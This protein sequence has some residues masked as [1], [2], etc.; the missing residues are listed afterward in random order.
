M[1]RCV[2]AAALSS[3]CVLWACGSGQPPEPP[4]PTEASVIDAQQ[5]GAATVTVQGIDVEHVHVSVSSQHPGTI[6]IPAGTVFGS[7]DAGTQN[8]M[9]ATTVRVVFA[10][11]PGQT[12][13]SPQV[14]SLDIEVYCINRMLDAP[15]PSSSYEVVSGGGELDPVRRL[16]ACLEHEDADHYSRQL[17]IWMTSDDF[18]QMSEDEVR[19]KL[20]GHAEDLL[21]SDRGAALLREKF[22][23][24]SDDE[25][26]Q[27]R[28][29]PE[30]RQV[31]M[32]AAGKEVD[33]EIDAYKSKAR[34][35]LEHCHFDLSTARF[36]QE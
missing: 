31:V 15:T 32:E 20:H 8:M 23:S 17:A 35:L 25:I 34:D 27:I 5:S 26:Q 33:Q 22:P 30:F 14:Q 7:R 16:A 21:N 18:L 24:L 10:G 19:Q 3:L 29:T 36:F 13:D 1:T 9:A 6:I 11:Q 2:H 12:F 28:Q 4:Q